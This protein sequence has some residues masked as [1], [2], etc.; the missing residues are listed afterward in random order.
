MMPA[1]ALLDERHR[2]ALVELFEC[3]VP[4]NLFALSWLDNYGVR[5]HRPDLFHHHGIF[6][7]S[8]R[9][10][11]AAALVISDRLL[12]LEAREPEGARALGTWYGRRGLHLHH[13]VSTRRCVEAFWPAY[14][15]ELDGLQAR[16]ISHQEL[17]T[18]EP[19]RFAG[20]FAGRERPEPSSVRLAILPDIEPLY[21]ASALMHREE[22]L[23]N[24]LETQPNS[25]RRHV[26]HRIE[27]DR[28]YVWFDDQ[29]RLRFKADISARSS[30]GVQLSGV[31]TAQP[32]RG[33]GLATRA[34]FDICDRLFE[35]GVRRITLYVNEDN[36]A[37]I[38]VYRRI[39]FQFHAPYQTV[40]VT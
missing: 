39:G 31:Y 29:R 34:L 13:I 38:R 18:L 11:M 14:R 37:A 26:R 24:P 16:M 19:E 4:S 7:A 22:T 27:H 9:G 12:L 35:A 3:D 40:F 8:G 23:E 32:F 2:G 28:S 25:F 10:L 17:Y 33:H 1:P 6:D 5:P 15:R 21:Y 20:H 36:H 30:R